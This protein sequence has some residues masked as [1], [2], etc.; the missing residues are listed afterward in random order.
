VPNRTVVVGF[1]GSAGRFDS[2]TTVTQ[3]LHSYFGELPRDILAALVNRRMVMLDFPLRGLHVEL[4]AVRTSTREGEAVARRTA[5]LLLLE[6]TASSTRGPSG[7]RAVA[8]RRYFY[9][10]LADRA[11]SEQEVAS[12][13]RRMRKLCAEDG[14]SSARS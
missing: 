10:W 12:I 13:L 2:G 1:N 8:R 7:R 14:P 5:S 9:R 3:F 6:A 11:P 4:E